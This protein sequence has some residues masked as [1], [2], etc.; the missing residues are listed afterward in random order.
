M[1]VDDRTMFCDKVPQVYK[2]EITTL[3]E[4][5]TVKAWTREKKLC[6]AILSSNTMPVSIVFTKL[7]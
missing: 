3:C 2:Q 4:A 6:K 7:T 5:Y 1:T